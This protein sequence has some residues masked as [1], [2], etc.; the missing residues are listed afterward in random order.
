MMNTYTNKA[1]IVVLKMP[2]M[3]IINTRGKIRG[4]ERGG[5]KGQHPLG[6][7]P[8]IQEAQFDIYYYFLPYKR[9]L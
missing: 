5:V 3:L 8:K 6:V 2:T 4:K 9:L 7:K 1:S